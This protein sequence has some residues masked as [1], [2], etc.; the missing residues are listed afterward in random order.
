LL[1]GGDPFGGLGVAE[2]AGD[3]E[4]AIG[5]PDAGD[6]LPAEA[7]DGRGYVREDLLATNSYCVCSL[8]D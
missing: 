3:A 7:A 8:R 6:E 5:E 4:E 2:R 1:T